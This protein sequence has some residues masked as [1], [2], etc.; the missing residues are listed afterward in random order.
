[1]PEPD[2]GAT[3]KWSKFRILFRAGCSKSSSA[4]DLCSGSASAAFLTPPLSWW[5]RWVDHHH[6]HHQ[7]HHHHHQH[8]CSRRHLDHVL[9]LSTSSG[10]ERPLRSGLEP[11]EV[12]ALRSCFSSSRD[13]SGWLSLSFSSPLPTSPPQFVWQCLKVDCPS[14]W[15]SE[16][17]W[18]RLRRLWGLGGARLRS[19]HSI[20][21]GQAH[22]PWWYKICW[23][24]WPIY[25]VLTRALEQAMEQV[26]Q[27]QEKAKEQKAALNKW[28]SDRGLAWDQAFDKFERFQGLKMVMC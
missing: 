5:V 28:I 3:K 17:S 9:S 15:V 7:R 25:N 4:T 24:K 26:T 20:R 13:R 8:W 18:Q 16:W 6:H 21:Q 27:A 22:K 12:S 1:M 10:V 11:L 23:N 19:G 14:V 2:F